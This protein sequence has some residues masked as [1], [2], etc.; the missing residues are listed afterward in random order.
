M[1]IYEVSFFQVPYPVPAVITLVYT[2]PL[3]SYSVCHTLVP[4]AAALPFTTTST[5][6]LT[7]P[8]YGAFAAVP[9]SL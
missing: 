8:L 5:Y 2:S 9:E 6:P 7:A 1:I 4:L 3:W